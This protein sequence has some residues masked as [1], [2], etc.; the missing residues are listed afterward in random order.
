MNLSNIRVMGLAVGVSLAF[1]AGCA[2]TGDDGGGE[3]SSG[4]TVIPPGSGG[5][6]SG[7]VTSGGVTSGGVTSGGGAG[8]GGGEVGGNGAGGSGSASNAGG[9]AAEGGATSGSGGEAGEG[10]GGAAPIDCDSDG[11]V[12]TYPTLPG[13]PESPL[14]TVTANGAAQFVEKMTKFGQEMQVHYAHFGVAS[15]CKATVAVTVNGGFNS[16]TLSPK[17]RMLSA[18]KNGDTLTFDSGPNYLILQIASK[19]LLFVLIDDQEVDPP[20]LGDADVKN[21]ADYNVDNTGAALVTSKVQAAIDAASGSAQNILY[22]PPGRYKTGE[23]WLKSNMTLYLAAGA[24]LD[25]STS[26][27]DYN[28]TGAPAVENTSHGVVHMNKVSNTKIL[29]RG[30]IDGNGSRIRGTNNDTPSF[31]INTL[32]IDDSTDVLVDGIVVRD[33]VFWN[34]L[35]FDSDKVTIQNFKVINR[36]PT[37]TA[38]NQT[39]G[40]DFDCS[41]NGKLYNAFIYSGDDSM[42]PKREQEGKLDTKAI[43]YEKVVAYSNSAATKIGTK[44]Y[45]QVIEDITFKDIDVVKAGRALGINA[46][47]TA[48]IQNITWQD[49]RV[50][51]VDG[52]IIDFEEDATATWRNA[53][54]RATVK[55]VFI[56][57]VASAVNK[58]IYIHGKSSTVNF[59]GIHFDNFTIQGNKVTSRN[60]WN[61]NQYVSNITFK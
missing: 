21:L 5:V 22:V 20:K 31:K 2:G 50:E 51:T 25:G 27:G 41:T 55:E 14:Y 58:E 44:T 45:G 37:T 57:N 4:G 36:R 54:N 6:T 42:S 13:A 8:T 19:E 1:G 46:D 30:V 23:V 15:G 12:M 49:V 43:T 32:R 56:N 11:A 33:P 39:D 24:I 16:Y 29:G 10:T 28:G 7:G 17:S 47:D 34:T 53:P 60:G 26:T 38:Y 48:V 3:T 35:I 52:R 40:V 9:S 59:N 61:V 18:T